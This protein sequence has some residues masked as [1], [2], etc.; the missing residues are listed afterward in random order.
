M[1]TTM[2]I[3]ASIEAQTILN[4]LS[5]DS[6]LAKYVDAS[7]GIPRIYCGSGEI[8]LVVLGQDPTVKNP[9]A[10]QK[11]DCALNLNHAGSLRNYLTRIYWDLGLDLEQHVYGTNLYKNFFVNPPTQITEI[12]IFH[13]ALP[14][15]LPLL[16]DELA[17]FPSALVITLGEPILSV[18]VNGPQKARLRDYWGYVPD[19]KQGN[20]KSFTFIAADQNIL[21]RVIFPFPHQPSLRKVLYKDRLRPYISFVKS[22]SQLF[23]T[24]VGNT[25]AL[26]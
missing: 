23:S 5:T 13:A 9:V 15:W 12:D 26:S 24:Q 16:K 11:I 18:L 7:L 10:R 1:E 17:Q 6:R 21:G 14:Y 4:R 19:W 22:Q 2:I 25:Y 8:R 3:D 20:S